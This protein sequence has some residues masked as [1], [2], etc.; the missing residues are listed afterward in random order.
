MIIVKI[1][2]HNTDKNIYIIISI[3]TV[4][5]IMILRNSNNN[6]NINK[7]NCKNT[8]SSITAIYHYIMGI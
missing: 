7:C 3:V 1:I 8:F 2:S 5:M 6:N 4:I